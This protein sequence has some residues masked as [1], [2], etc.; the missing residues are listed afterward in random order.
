MEQ[1]ANCLFLFSGLM[2]A[3][4][5]ISYAVHTRIW[6]ALW[7]LFP[8]SIFVLIVLVSMARKLLEEKDDRRDNTKVH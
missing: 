8:I 4:S 3:V 5:A 1:V 6:S 7:L 2:F